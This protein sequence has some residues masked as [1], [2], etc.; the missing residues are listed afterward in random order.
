MKRHRPRHDL[1]RQQRAETHKERVAKQLE[2]NA[3]LAE[4]MRTI[5]HKEYI[6]ALR[7]MP[8]RPKPE[9]AV[10][11]AVYRRVMNRQKAERRAR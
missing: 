9:D 5:P 7:A 6:A 10:D 3:K 2:T 8:V 11:L 1:T 4:H